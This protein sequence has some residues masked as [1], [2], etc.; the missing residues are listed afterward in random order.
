M[1]HKTKEAY[2][3]LIPPRYQRAARS[4]KKRILDEFCAVRRYP[5][6]HAI[7]LL[8]EPIRVKKKACQKRGPNPFYQDEIFVTA[9]QQMYG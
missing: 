9:L 3:Q 7:T 1:N 5:R 8:K 2:Q 4:V 6:K